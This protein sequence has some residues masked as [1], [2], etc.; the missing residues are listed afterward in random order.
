[1]TIF[2][3]I[4]PPIPSENPSEDGKGRAKDFHY[5]W[6][7]LPIPSPLSKPADRMGQGRARVPIGR[8]SR[9]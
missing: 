5:L 8:K 3:P 4:F 9:E 2:P 7:E 1:M 6:A